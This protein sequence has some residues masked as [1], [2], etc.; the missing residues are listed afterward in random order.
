M[1]ALILYQGMPTYVLVH[2]KYLLTLR[3]TFTWQLTRKTIDTPSK[4]T[5]VG[6]GCFNAACQV[7]WLLTYFCKMTQMF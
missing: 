1:V 6:F 5:I 3:T 2:I 7:F 4:D